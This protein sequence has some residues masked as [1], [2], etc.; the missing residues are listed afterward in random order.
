M[1]SDC[2]Y[3]EG[4]LKSCQR[5]EHDHSQQEKWRHLKEGVP[6]KEEMVARLNQ[7]ID[8]PVADK[9]WYAN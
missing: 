2:R 5:E 6:V 7:M 3:S 1:K 8:G 4:I 9:T